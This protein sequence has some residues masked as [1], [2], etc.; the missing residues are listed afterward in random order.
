MKTAK[1]QKMHSKSNFNFLMFFTFIIFGHFKT[2][3]QLSS[4][5]VAGGTA[6]IND[7]Y[8]RTNG[9]GEVFLRLTQKIGWYFNGHLAI[10]VNQTYFSLTP[11]LGRDY[12]DIRNKY[13]LLQVG[14]RFNVLSAIRTARQGGRSAIGPVRISCKGFKWYI[15]AGYEYLYLK[16]TKDKKS[17]QAI[18]N[19]WAGTGF[20]ILRIGRG[21]KTK[22]PTIINFFEFK[23]SKLF[24]D[25]Y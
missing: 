18:S 24:L 13:N 8:Y 20:N 10:G 23:F 17:A 9:T 7:P 16:E 12:T 15:M 22:Y 5:E 3:S 6:G 14:A 25:T 21:S 11:T 2:F 19:F 1:N 4:V